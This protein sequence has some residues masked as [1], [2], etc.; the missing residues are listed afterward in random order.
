[1]LSIKVFKL[2]KVFSNITTVSE[3]KLSVVKVIP[4]IEAETS[5]TV[6]SIPC[7]GISALNS[8][9]VKKPSVDKKK[10]GNALLKLE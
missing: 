10:N 9:I 6:A 5:G 4:V 3:Y 8:V 1:M 2:S 7:A